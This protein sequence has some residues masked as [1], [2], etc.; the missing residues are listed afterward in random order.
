[1]GAGLGIYRS[2]TAAA[3]AVLVP[4]LRLLARTEGTLRAS[5]RP[6]GHEALAARGAT[7][8]HAASMG[9]MV[10]ARRWA[11]TLS[12]AGS[13]TPFHVT[14][15]TQAGLARAR[16]ELGGLAVAAIAP[17]DF[18]AVVR[19]A[20]RALAPARLDLIETE[21]WPNLLLEAR[22][23]GVPVVFVSGSVSPATVSRL[24][25]CGVSG[26][27]LFGDGVWVLAQSRRAAEGFS[28]LGVPAERI[29]VV[30]DLKAEPPAEASF[31]PP[32]R[33]PL[34]AFGSLRP[35]EEEAAV[36]TARVLAPGRLRLLVAPRHREGQVRVEARL[37]H[38]GFSPLTRDEG[39]APRESLAAWLA[40]VGS[41]S[42]ST[43][44]VLATRGELG[45]AY[46]SAAIAVVGGSF[47]TYGGHN[48]LEPAARGCPVIVGPHHEE[49]QAAVEALLARGGAA[50]VS[51]GTELAGALARWAD[52]PVDRDAAGD[53]ASSAAADAARSAERALGALCAFGLQP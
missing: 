45:T 28:R 22:T 30:G 17:L 7:W 52:D 20:L 26:R 31:P 21:I 35:G 23:C 13:R 32:S 14:A 44:G 12:G 53:G 18:P 25:R 50:V 4:P 43:V 15:R 46:E 16:K 38:A 11:E 9:E 1:M 6:P 2:L 29:A 51:S 47:A 42:G 39:S 41:A 3:G 34:V 19:S 10:A 24:A 33:R 8:I 36:T 49:V 40:R 27:R 48:A 37:A 5:L